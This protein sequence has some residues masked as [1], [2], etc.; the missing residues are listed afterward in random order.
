M[1]G[2]KPGLLKRNKTVKRVKVMEQKNGGTHT[3]F[4]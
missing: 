4:S 1:G 3:L 2:L